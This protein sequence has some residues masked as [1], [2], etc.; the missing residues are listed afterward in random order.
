M[1][2]VCSGA[3]YAT[4]PATMSASVSGR[5]SGRSLSFESPKSTTLGT[6]RSRASRARK[7]F[8]GL[9]SR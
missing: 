7:T 3:M 5:L 4:E 6:I 1:P 2:Y 9:M 8:A